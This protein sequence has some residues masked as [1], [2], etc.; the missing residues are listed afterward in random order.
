MGMNNS[1]LTN[2]SNNYIRKSR[3]FHDA[4]AFILYMMLYVGTTT[5][6]V[7]SPK[8][9]QITIDFSD[10]LN[11]LI[12]CF[13][14]VVLFI[15]M[16]F[17]GLR[18]F[19]EFFL[20]FTICMFPVI[21]IILSIVFFNIVSFIIA[22]ISVVLWGIFV[23]SYWSILKYVGKVLSYTVGILIQNISAVFLGI[24]LC[25]FLQI[26]QFCLTRT[27]DFENLQKNLLLYILLILNLYWSITNFIYFFK[28]YATS[29]VAHHFINLQNSS[30]SVFGDSI[31][32][33]FYALGSISFAGFIVAIVSTL[34]Y[35]VNNERRSRRDSRD[36]NIVADILLCLVEVLLSVL[37]QFIEFA[38]EITLPYLAIHGEGYVDSMK[39]AKNFMRENNLPLGGLVAISYSLFISSF[40]V[41]VLCAGS[42]FYSVS[43]FAGSLNAKIVIKLVLTTL[44]P[45]VIY[46]T[47]MMIISSSFLGIVY[48]TAENPDLVRNAYS[49]LEINMKNC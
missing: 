18:L 6:T 46:F 41:S 7:L 23:Y 29:I 16:N 22:I 17:G 28:V 44:I 32:N 3:K 26:F 37:Q 31:A 9:D 12:T 5:Y 19:P 38:N 33:T 15:L 14:I 1:I 42:A 10:N 35:F 45:L 2:N 13:G 34:R 24:L 39:N 48:F 30:I 47:T 4:W 11:H 27:V 36:R 8:N 25:S 49:E 43:R 40:L 21:T 20:K